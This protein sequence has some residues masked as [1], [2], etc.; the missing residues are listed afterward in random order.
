MEWIPERVLQKYVQKNKEKFAKHFDGTITSV[1]WNNDR[2]PDLTF[3]IDGNIEIPVEVEWKTSNFIQHKH[4]PEVLL[5]GDGLLIVGKIEPECDVGKIKQ[6]ELSLEDFEKWF[7]RNSG[8]LVKETTK[9]L[10]EIDKKR[11]I[12]KLW[13][14]YLSFKGDAVTHFETALK[15]QVWGIQENYNPTADSQIKGIKK[16]DLIAFI[17]PGKKFPGRVPISEWTKKSFKGI[18]E[19][20]RVYKITGGYYKEYTK[21]WDVKGK[22]KNELFP[23]RFKFDRNPIILVKNCKISNLGLTSK[24]EL[25]KTVYSN[26]RMA[27]PF[28]LVDIL[29]HTDQLTIGESKEELEKVQALI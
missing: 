21:I 29:H 1:I 6:V 2:Y 16:G 20:I 3:V 8:W 27:D 19:K 13:F 11:T 7:K 14:T 25:H 12:P 5:E 4:P 10:H 15:H 28:S 17:G 18:F 9:G 23:H 26:I 24:K 22:W